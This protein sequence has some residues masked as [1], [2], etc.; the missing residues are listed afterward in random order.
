M[1]AL[2]KTFAYDRSLL[3]PDLAELRYRASVRPGVQQSYAQM[4][5]APRQEGVDALAVPEDA[6]RA[7]PHQTLIVHG[8]ED[9][10]HPHRRRCGC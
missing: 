3:G 10:G 9:P 1:A 4:F 8:P 5:P 2:L 7:L 6:L